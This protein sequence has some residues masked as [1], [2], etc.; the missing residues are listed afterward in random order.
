M[1]PP[2]YMRSIIDRKVVMRR[3]PVYLYVHVTECVIQL[4]RVLTISHC[5]YY[6]ASG[7]FL[8]KTSRKSSQFLKNWMCL[9]KFYGMFY[10]F[11]YHCTIDKSR[12]QLVLNPLCNDSKEIICKCQIFH[13]LSGFYARLQSFV[14]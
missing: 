1:G 14:F 9:L 2:S 6:L 4:G 5:L 7:R 8:F 10:V 3:I 12:N 13:E 11:C